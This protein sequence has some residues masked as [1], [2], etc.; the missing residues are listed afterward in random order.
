MDF[1]STEEQLVLAT[2]FGQLFA[3]ESSMERVRAAELAGGF[4]VALWRSFLEL[5]GPAIA[6]R[7][8]AGGGGADLRHLG[9]VVEL[10]GRWLAPVPIV[11]SFV[12][13][14]LL[15]RLGAVAAPCLERVVAGDIVTIALRPWLP[16]V[17]EVVPAGAVS[18]GVVGL[19]GD[20]L[21]WLLLSD[22]R[23]T[24]VANHGSAPLR[25][26]SANDADERL[27][28]CESTEAL[29][30]F[31]EAVQ[32]WKILTAGALVGLAQSALE[33][34]AEYAK[35]RE[36]F[37]G[38][39]GRFQAIAHPLA[40]GL[41]AID[42]ARL[43]CLE[44]QWA[45]DDGN[46]RAGAL[47]S[48]AFAFAAETASR[49]VAHALHVH[50]GYGLTIEYDIQLYQRRAKAWALVAGDPRLEY[51]RVADELFGAASLPDVIGAGIA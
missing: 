37:G 18:R 49:V 36:Q 31:G 8:E 34:G 42:G 6:A 45:T 50:G 43:L 3:K 32:D 1:S 33:L 22:D 41:A 29:A 20:E 27:V 14:R 19:D 24:A 40:D 35:T 25:L 4:D 10:C 23:G 13:A 26:L 28:L 30:A 46:P 16:G 21:V 38:A 47:A 17:V 2:V 39:I 11:E 48:M 51:Q 9:V 44:A 7:A 12:T 15:G 5:G